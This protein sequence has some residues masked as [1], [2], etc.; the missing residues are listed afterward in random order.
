M[1]R[2]EHEK[3]PGVAVG[4]WEAWIAERW[5]VQVLP[6]EQG[7]EGARGSWRGRQEPDD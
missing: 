6:R 2:D 1:G 4:G 7:I 5:L 3:V